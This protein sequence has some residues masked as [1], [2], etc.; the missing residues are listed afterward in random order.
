MIFGE[1]GEEGGGAFR[2]IIKE[3]RPK[4]SKNKENLGLR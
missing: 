2:Q 4:G 1:N 3:Q